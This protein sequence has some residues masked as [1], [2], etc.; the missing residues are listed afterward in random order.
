VKH[1]ART[2]I[3]TWWVCAMTAVFGA[4]TPVHACSGP[5][6]TDAEFFPARGT[7]P[8]NL[9]A[10]LFW[11]SSRSDGDGDD[12]GH[13]PVAS[14]DVRFVRLDAAGPVA[15]D[16]EVVPSHEPST[17]FGAGTASAPAY[18][19]VPAEELQPGARYAVWARDCRGDIFAEPPL[20]PY[21]VMHEPTPDAPDLVLA[22]RAPYAVFDAAAAAPLP[23]ALGRM[24]VSQPVQREVALGG[25]AGCFDQYRAATV[26]AELDRE[27][28]RFFDA[29][30][31]VTYVDDEVYRP[32][33]HLNYAPAYG[34]SWIGHG[35]DQLA[36]L[37]ESGRRG[38]IAVG[39]HT[40]RFEG[41]VAGT[42][43]VVIGET[44]EFELSC[45]ESVDAGAVADGGSALDAGASGSHGGPGGGDADVPFDA[46]SRSRESSRKGGDS[47]GCMVA[48][49][50]HG[51]VFAALL[52]LALLRGRRRTT[53]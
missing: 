47:G 4:P 36:A 29:I 15:V 6:C 27:A 24:T 45:E 2:C 43:Q 51:E 1:R 30:A 14:N 5:S 42:D 13:D 26:L 8:A 48:G 44:I 41:S 17:R 39:R 9:P 7:V 28:E 22:P 23:N 34:D 11:P 52:A 46:A 3:V 31:F 32:S 10:V 12:A 20:E 16:F 19:L 53:G 50:A 33:P 38:P 49:A 25:G 21:S 40:V 37:C 18:R 35:R